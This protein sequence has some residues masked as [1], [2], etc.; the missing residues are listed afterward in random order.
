MNSK[1]ALT[2]I[3]MFAAI[4]GLGITSPA[5]AAPG[6]PNSNATT[7]VCHLFEAVENNPETPEDESEPAHWGGLY[8][9]SNGATNGHLK[10]GDSL[11]GE[12]TD[13]AAEPPTITVED[14]IVL[15]VPEPEPVP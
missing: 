4:M 8:T 3:A 2:A 5:M 1:L 14:C 7:Q 10:H 13:L 15:P 6:N 12:V 9:S 11:I